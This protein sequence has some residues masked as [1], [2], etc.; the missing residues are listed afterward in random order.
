MKTHLREPGEE[1]QELRR[2]LYHLTEEVFKLQTVQRKFALS[3]SRYERVSTK[4]DSHGDIL[5]YLLGMSDFRP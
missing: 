3:L 1:I 2:R 4:N 5:C